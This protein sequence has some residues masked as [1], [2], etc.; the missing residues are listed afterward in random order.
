[1]TGERPIPASDG[2]RLIHVVV[3]EILVGVLFNALVFPYLIWLV[4]LTPPAALGGPDGVVAS[5]TKATVFAVSLMTVILTMVWRK[6]AA[7]GA[8]PVVGSAIRRWA[9]FAPRNILGRALFFV[10]LSLATLTPIG[11]AACWWFGLY[12]MTKLSFAAF[13]VCFGALIG[14]VVTPFITLAAMF[15]GALTD[16][17]HAPGSHRG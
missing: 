8:V 7:K 5:L 9:R 3:R 2:G 1:M 11:V 15:D 13:N 10:I 4:N 14:T 12:P 6:K 17:R 16:G